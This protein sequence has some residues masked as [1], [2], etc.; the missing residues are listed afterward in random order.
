MAVIPAPLMDSCSEVMI[1]GLPIVTISVPG[2]P[3]T[4]P[5][6]GPLRPRMTVASLG[7]VLLPWIGRM[8]DCSIT[9]GW[10]VKVPETGV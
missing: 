4:A 9:P 2:L 8:K 10:K 1:S 7:F 3:R 6:V 5:P